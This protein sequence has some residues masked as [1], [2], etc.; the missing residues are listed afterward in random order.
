VLIHTADP[1]SFFDPLDERNERWEELQRHPDWWF[2]GAEYPTFAALMG[3]LDR[4]LDACPA[5]TFIGA[6]VGCWA[7]DLGAVGHMLRDHDHWHADLGGRL[8]EIGRQPRRF[9]ELVSRFPDRVLFGTDA[10]PPAVDD[11]L[12]Y[13]RF[14][15]TADEHFDY[16]GEPTPPQGRWAISGCELPMQLLERVYWGNAARIL[17]LE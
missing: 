1:A 17:R 12:R 15:E 13:Y 11:Y 6:H 7:E 2:G 10:F 16:S 14:L 9:A 3:S 8:A 5:T 4:L